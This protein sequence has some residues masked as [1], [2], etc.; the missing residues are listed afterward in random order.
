ME[1]YEMSER[2][3]FK[4]QNELAQLASRLIEKYPGGYLSGIEIVMSQCGIAIRGA[5]RGLDTPRAIITGSYQEQHAFECVY[6]RMRE[7]V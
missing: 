4:V 2:T 7:A 1:V 5:L 3:I 6:G